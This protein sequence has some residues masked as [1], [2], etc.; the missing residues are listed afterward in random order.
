MADEGSRENVDA[1][2]RRLTAT[3]VRERAGAVGADGGDESVELCD[4]F[5]TYER[6]GADALLPPGVYTVRPQRRC[7]LLPPRADAPARR[8]CTT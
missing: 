3:W 6:A 2:C 5:E 8:S 7:A 4:F 1:G